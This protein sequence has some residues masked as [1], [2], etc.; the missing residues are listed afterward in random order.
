MCKCLAL[1]L[2]LCVV[3]AAGAVTT[4]SNS[5]SL[6]GK[7]LTNGDGATGPRT[8]G[9]TIAQAT[10]IP[11]I[12][13]FSDT[14][15]TCSYAND[16]D[17]VCPY[18]GSTAPDVV[19]AFTPTEAAT[20]TVDLCA[21][22]YDTKVYVYAGGVGN[23]VGCNDDAGCGYSGWQSKVAGVAVTPGVTYYI[24]VD[25][26]GSSCGTYDLQVSCCPPPCVVDC[27]AGAVQEGEPLCSDNY[28][29]NYNGG[30]NSSPNVF[31]TLNATAGDAV[32]LCG[33]SGTY[34]F[35]GSSYRDTD[36]YDVT[37]G[38]GGV[39][40]MQCTAEFPLLNFL[41]YGL[42]CAAPGYV[43][44]TADPCVTLNLSY[45]FA[46]GAHAWLWVGPSVFEGVPCDAGYLMHVSG[47]TPAPVPVE[48][49]SWGWVK[50]RYR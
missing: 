17:E 5:I 34:L 24:V 30:C 29:D 38:I 25:G 7:G 19:Y 11:S 15:A 36:W 10:F 14:G 20:I 13:G 35:N 28:V 43:Y 45:G 12:H 48:R 31:Q 21:S 9:D 42:N 50:S 8:G 33:K 37:V 2:V 4:T 18:T 23:L 40:A 41:F 49:A 1:V 26:Y 44:G 3:G 27:P 6:E 46:V 39:L 47:L 32:D 22:Q 16:Y